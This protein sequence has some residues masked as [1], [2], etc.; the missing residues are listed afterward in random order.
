MFECH[1]D[2]DLAGLP[3]QELGALVAENAAGRRAREA[4][5]LVLAA[6]WADAHD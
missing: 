3:I 5:D 1:A 4:R 2:E 6:A